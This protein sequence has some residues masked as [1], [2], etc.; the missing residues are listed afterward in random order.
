MATVL[1]SLGITFFVLLYFLPSGIAYCLKGKYPLPVIIIL[2][3]LLGWTI[4]GWL[5]MLLWVVLTKTPPVDVQQVKRRM[6]IIAA[7]MVLL[8][9]ILCIGSTYVSRLSF[10][11]GPK[12]TSWDLSTH[13]VYLKPPYPFAELRSDTA[14][15]ASSS[16]YVHC[17]DGFLNVHIGTRIHDILPGDAGDKVVEARHRVGTGEWVHLDWVAKRGGVTYPRNTDFADFVKSLDQENA[18]LTVEFSVGTTVQFPVWNGYD[19]M[20]EHITCVE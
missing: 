4:I 1:V 14:H 12:D 6:C 9:I 18:D 8:F 10:G 17:R 15:G 11:Q 7:V 13:Y 5:W 20:R 19:K 16:L 2:N 3:I